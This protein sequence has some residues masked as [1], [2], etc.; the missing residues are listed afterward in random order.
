MDYTYINFDT[1]GWHQAYFMMFD[2]PAEQN[3]KSF[4]CG[5]ECTQ[6]R[7]FI[8]STV[9]QRVS[10]GA[11]TYTFYTYPDAFGECP[12]GNNDR[13]LEDAEWDVINLVEY[14]NSS[15]N[16]IGNRRDNTSKSFTNGAGWLE[17]IEIE[18]GEEVE[19]VV[20]FNWARTGVTKD[21]SVTAWGEI[22]EVEVR[23]SNDIESNHFPY[24]EKGQMN[25]D[26]PKPTPE[27]APIEQEESSNE[28][29]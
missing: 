2:D 9:K 5:S 22:G 26:P 27:E 12:V 15:T 17:T 20:E 24:T 7:L 1:A 23:H 13:Q 21:W 19:I 4:V 3:G 10:V 28:D 16:Y 14:D 18:A 29:I 11:H 6:H 25:I 8:K